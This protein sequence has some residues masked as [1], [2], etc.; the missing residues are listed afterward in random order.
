MAT[1]DTVTPTISASCCLAGVAPTRKP[2]FR[3]CEVLPAFA[4]AIQTTP[5]IVI[6]SAENAVAVQPMT[7]NMAH[8]AISVAIAMPEIG[9]EELPIKPGNARRDRDKQESENHYQNG[10]AR[11]CLRPLRFRRL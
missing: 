5:P 2:V 8:V 1:T 7:R 9:F 6:A 10:G 3:S 4:D 11:R